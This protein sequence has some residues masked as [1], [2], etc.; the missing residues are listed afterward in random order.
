M[1]LKGTGGFVAPIIGGNGGVA[2][3]SVSISQPICTAPCGATTDKQGL[4]WVSG[5]IGIRD[6][7]TFSLPDADP[8]KLRVSAGLRY[9][10]AAGA[11]AGVLGVLGVLTGGALIP[12]AATRT[13]A[14][15]RDL[16]RSLFIAAGASL[17][18]GLVLCVTAFLLDAASK[19]SVWHGR[20]QL[21]QDGA[22]ALHF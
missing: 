16:R 5:P 21:A 4:Y 3:G 12:L 20:N 11:T 13:D 15:E 18:G 6:S 19:T 7:S 8:A 17:G 22:Q 9:G 14:D 1:K 10:V 2:Y